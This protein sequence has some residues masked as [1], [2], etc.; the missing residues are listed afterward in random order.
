MRVVIGTNKA[1][2]ICVEGR[3]HHV[4][5]GRGGDDVIWDAAASDVIH[6]GSGNDTVYANGGQDTV[7]GGDGSDTIYGG[8]GDDTITGLA[9]NDD[10]AGAEGDDVVHGGEGAD[11]VDGGNGGDAVSGDA[12]GDLA[13]GGPGPD[14]VDGG[15]GS[16]L[17]LGGDNSDQ[18]TGGAGDDQVNGGLGDD[19]LSGGPGTNTCDGG[20]GNDHL[21]LTCDSSKPQL[22]WMSFSQTSADSSQSDVQVTVTARFTDDLSGFDAATIG[23]YAG[24]AHFTLADQ[25]SGDALDGVYRTTF[26]VRRY[27]STGTWPLSVITR[28]RVGNWGWGSSSQ[29]QSLDLPW[30]FSQTGPGDDTAPTASTISLSS[31]SL[32]SS[33]GPA[34]IDATVHVDDDMSGFGSLLI[35]LNGPAGQIGRLYFNHAARTSGTAV[36]GDYAGSI[37]LPH[38]AASGDW[39]VA[40]GTIDDLAGNRRN[41]STAEAVALLGGVEAV[42]ET[43]LGDDTPPVAE[44]LSVTSDGTDPSIGDVQVNMTMHATDDLSGFSHAD[45]LA[46]PP[47]IVIYRDVYVSWG[48][49]IS[50]DTM[51]GNYQLT[52]TIPQYSQRGLW[53]V[54]CRLYDFV[55]NHTTTPTAVMQIG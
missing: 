52:F 24:E 17:V 25:I 29:L 15:D 41:F 36:S 39:Q 12:G 6:G 53:T 10:L 19:D 1:D 16:D 54:T 55:G 21:D 3:G 22:Q 13:A 42:T 30:Q 48:S 46:S 9:G 32:D 50:G 34:S 51:D 49:R 33:S 37:D 11:S 31:T 35:I 20:G 7:F 14:T 47:S 27:T 23:S 28:D 18:L 44:S 40:G 45:C 5:Y 26:T 43:G 2:R 4:I 38:F 8:A